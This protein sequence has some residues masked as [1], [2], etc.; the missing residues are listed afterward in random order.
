MLPYNTFGLDVQAEYF[1]EAR[2]ADDLRHILRQAPKPWLILGGGSNIVFARDVP[3]TVIKNSLRGIHP[4]GESADTLRL[5]VGAGE[6][7]HH[8]VQHCVAN[9]LGGLENLSLIPGTVGAAPI[10]N[11]GAYGVELKDSLVEV[12]ALDLDDLDAPLRTFSREDCRFGY[13]DSIFKREAKGRYCITAVT[14]ALSRSG[15]HRLN[16]SY[17]DIQRTLADM[18]VQSPS[19]ADIS[20]AVVRIRS[21]KLPDPAVLGNCGS[22]FKNPEV[23]RSV[24][25]RVQ[26]THPQA[27][28]YDLPDGRVKIPAGWLIEQCGWKGKRMGN[29]GSYEKQALVLVNHGGATGDEVWALAQAIMNSVAARFGIQLEPE[30]NVY[31]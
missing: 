23:E 30:V 1:A 8:L 18:Q 7:W 27:P 14:F 12:E 15:H 31:R 17:G 22:F 19:I 6:V 4:A 29:V 3:G 16:T 21:S 11:I 2:T 25:E 20:R 5:K 13:R 28:H 10:Q 26:S 24:L 9:D